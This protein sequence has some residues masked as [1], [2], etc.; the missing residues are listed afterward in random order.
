[1]YIH[2]DIHIYIHIYM[3]VCIYICIHID[4]CIYIIIYVYIYIYRCTYVYIYM[5]IYIFTYIYICISA[6][7]C[8][9][10]WVSGHVV[11]SRGSEGFQARPHTV[12]IYGMS[13]R[14]YLHT[15]CVC[16]S[17]YIYIYVHV[18]LP[19]YIASF[20]DGVDLTVL[21]HD[22]TFLSPLTLQ[23]ELTLS[24]TIVGSSV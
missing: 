5:C 24:R 18:S 1:M 19:T 11:Y 20:L 7:V 16:V 14:M 21:S 10:C 2:L 12:P 22:I 15:Y 23:S 17:V 6:V 9:S 4:V 8:L 13:A 3:Y